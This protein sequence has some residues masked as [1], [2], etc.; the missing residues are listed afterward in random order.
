MHQF[1]RPE[2]SLATVTEFSLATVTKFPLATLIELALATDN[3]FALAQPSLLQ[4]MHHGRVDMLRCMDKPA[5]SIPI[6]IFFTVSC[7]LE[8]LLVDKELVYT[9][10]IFDITRIFETKNKQTRDKLK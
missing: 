3:E 10:E 5:Q 2:F 6:T 1:T 7:L 4:P 8:F 9:P